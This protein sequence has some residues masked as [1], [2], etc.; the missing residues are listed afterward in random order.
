MIK[1]IKGHDDI[2][3]EDFIKSVKEAKMRCSQQDLL[4]NFIIAKKLKGT[5]KK[6][7]ATP[8]TWKR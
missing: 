1:E 6:L 2:G 5:Q 3:I 4:L 8:A 7:Y